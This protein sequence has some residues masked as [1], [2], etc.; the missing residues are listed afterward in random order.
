MKLNF[1][2]VASIVY[3][4]YQQQKINFTYDVLI[5]SNTVHCSSYS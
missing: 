4:V 5:I 3:T 1:V 2:T